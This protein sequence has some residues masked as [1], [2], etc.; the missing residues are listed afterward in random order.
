MLALD[1]EAFDQYT[2][3]R[4]SNRV[5]IVIPRMDGNRLR[6][7]PG[8]FGHALLKKLLN[9]LLNLMLRCC[10][11]RVEAIV[12]FEPVNSHLVQPESS[13]ETRNKLVLRV[14]RVAG[15]VKEFIQD[16]MQEAQC[17]H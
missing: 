9:G 5:Q 12:Q 16:R 13:S 11:C 3:I 15:T 4:A 2:S 14:S 7:Q 6:T 17:T 10:A 8:H 1:V